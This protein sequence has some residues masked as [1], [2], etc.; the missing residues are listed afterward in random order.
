MKSGYAYIFVGATGAGKSTLIK[1]LISRVNVERLHV[2]DINDEYKLGDYADLPDMKDFLNL[3]TSLRSSVIVFEDATVFFSNRGRD[4]QMVKLLVS[5][6]HRKNV[7]LLA[8]HS[9]R[10]IP[11]NIYNLCN[12]IFVCK[13]ND[14]ADLVEKRIPGLFEAFEKVRDGAPTKYP[15]VNY[16]FVSLV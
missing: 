16:K 15:Y 3:A 2:Y 6:R 13:T 11:F 4:A 9:I 1:R 14:T 5:K 12:G 10:D 8:F 7:I